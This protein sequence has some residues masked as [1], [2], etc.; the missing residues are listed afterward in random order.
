MFVSMVGFSTRVIPNL[1]T[2]AEVLRAISRK[3]QYVTL[4]R[5]M[6]RRNLFRN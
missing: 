3:G 6:T 5:A 2:V 4:L 1:A